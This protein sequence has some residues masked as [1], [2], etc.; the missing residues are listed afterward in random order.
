VRTAVETA[1]NGL[2][3]LRLAAAPGE[4]GRIGAPWTHCPAIL[5]V[6]FAPSDP[7]QPPATVRDRRPA[8]SQRNQIAATAS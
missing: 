7:A 8:R 4:L 2:P 3:G 6:T 5:P 1:L